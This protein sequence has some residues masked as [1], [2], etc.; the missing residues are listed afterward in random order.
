MSSLLLQRESAHANLGLIGRDG[1]ASD[2]ASAH[3]AHTNRIKSAWPS[4]SKPLH[5]QQNHRGSSLARFG[6]VSMEI[7]IQR[8]TNS[9]FAARPIQDDLVFSI[10]HPDFRNVNG[11]KS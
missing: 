6:E 5:S 11:V 7:M 3:W 2:S 4:E 10:L 1:S 8:N 9:V